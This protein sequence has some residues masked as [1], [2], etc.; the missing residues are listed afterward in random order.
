MAKPKSDTRTKNWAAVFYP[1]SLPENW[2][3]LCRELLT[4]IIISP[5]HDKDVQPD[6]TKKKPHYHVIFKFT[7]NKTFEQVKKMLEPFNCPIPQKVTSIKGAVRYLI[8]IDDPDKA[9][10]NKSDIQIIGNVDIAPYFQITQTD[11]YSLIKE[12][13]EFV[14]DN[15]L[16]EFSTLLDYATVHRPD[17]WFPLLCDNS[18]YVVDK[19][20]T[21]LRNKL[22]EE[23]Q[24]DLISKT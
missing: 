11:R 8:H 1:D 23:H 5:L 22:K 6:G 17:D 14:S 2:L 19:Y 4:D 10:Y 18:A 9:Q 20:I 15:Q 21:S 12:M 24:L 3:S 13:I 16:T 7:S